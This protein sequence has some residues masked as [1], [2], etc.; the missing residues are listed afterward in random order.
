MRVVRILPE[1]IGALVENRAD[2]RRSFRVRTVDDSSPWRLTTN[3]SVPIV[4][5]DLRGPFLDHTRDV[6]KREA[7]AASVTPRR[8]GHAPISK[9]LRGSI[10]LIS[11]QRFSASIRKH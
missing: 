5:E 2:E 1:W 7:R 10:H 9:S 4:R 8:N 3:A 6:V 11:L